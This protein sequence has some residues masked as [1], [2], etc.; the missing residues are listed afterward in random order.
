MKKPLKIAL[1]AGAVV[2]ALVLVAVI[3]VGSNL[4]H[5]VKKVVTSTGTEMLGTRVSLGEVKLA[6]TEGSGG[7]Y[8][9]TI[10]NPPGFSEANAFELDEVSLKLEIASV[11]TD[12]IVIDR[13]VIDG[14][15]VLLEEKGGATNLKT[16]S[17]RLT[18][19][20][21]DSGGTSGQPTEPT[22]ETEGPRLVIREF[23]FTNAHVRVVS[24]KLAGESSATLPDIVLKDIGR[25]GAGVT[26]AE[27]TKQ[28]LAPLMRKTIEAAGRKL[29][30]KEAGKG[31]RGLL[32]KALGN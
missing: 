11:T 28:I 25:N 14:A 17:D 12:E 4:N 1:I 24:E 21:T 10:A 9:L 32:D 27:A 5:I 23:R 19:T 13:V 3:A 26:A 16:L 8:R 2:A 7:L 18:Q 6:L 31:L 30:E 15:R 20:P 29:L 22:A